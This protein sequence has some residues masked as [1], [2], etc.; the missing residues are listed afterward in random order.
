LKA[1][2]ARVGAA[3]ANRFPRISLTG[4]FG[5]A[6]QELGDL[7][8]PESE[9]WNLALGLTQPIF[10]AGRLKS[11]QTIAEAR[12]EQ[13]VINYSKTVLNAFAEVEGALLTRKEQLRRRE[14]VITFLE[15]AR[16]TQKVAQMRYDRG[17]VDYLSVLDAQQV[18]LTAEE[19][20][21]QVDQAIF[22]NRVTL[23]RALGG[24]W[25]EEEKS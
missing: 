19:D 2:N 11:E 8:R 9:L 6:S 3:Y 21:V 25:G 17:L 15:E 5:Y 14:R 13:G 10:D 22:Q 18:T 24:G 23:H 1:L 7:F 20:L 12:F 4:S 16:A